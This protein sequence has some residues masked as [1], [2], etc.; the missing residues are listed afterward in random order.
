[1]FLSTTERKIELQQDILKSSREKALAGDSKRT[2]L[3]RHVADTILKEIRG[4]SYVVGDRLPPENILQ[5]R[6]RV[7][8]VV[9]RQAMGLLETK[10]II[11]REPGRGTFVEA[12]PSSSL[13]SSLGANRSVVGILSGYLMGTRDSYVAPILHALT[14]RLA[15]FS[16]TPGL[17]NIFGADEAFDVKKVDRYQELDG[18]IVLMPDYPVKSEKVV[19]E[20]LKTEIPIIGLNFKSDITDCVYPDHYHGGMLAGEHLLGLGHRDFWCFKLLNPPM[21]WVERVE[22]F[23]DVLGKSSER[24][25]IKEI[26]FKNEDVYSVIC[27]L[28]QEKKELPSA[29]FVGDDRMAA[30]IITALARFDIRVP[31]DISVMAYNDIHITETHIPPLST[32]HVPLQEMANHAVGLLEKKMTSG[33]ASSTNQQFILSPV[34]KTRKTTGPV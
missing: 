6:F 20:L 4:G 23:K 28:V 22:G 1:L 10:N 27:D 26:E 11:R 33:I 9:V 19:S 15:N 7:S 21:S 13:N 18:V 34:L 8:R 25:A 5:K 12:P 31:K 16:R 29:I 14:E 17:Y 3:Y 32:I 24:V 2:F 30:S